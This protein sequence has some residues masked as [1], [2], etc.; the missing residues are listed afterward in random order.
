GGA[1]LGAAFA[2][3]GGGLLARSNARWMASR[4]LSGRPLPPSRSPLRAC[5][6]WGPTGFGLL[7]GFWL[8][9]ASPGGGALGGAAGDDVSL[10][11]LSFGYF[12]SGTTDCVSVRRL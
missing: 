3:L 12:N 10:M 2:V 5:G 7:T 4:R 1:D 6:A 11:M 8:M 9:T